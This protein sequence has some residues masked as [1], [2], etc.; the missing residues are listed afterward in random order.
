M[1]RLP[2][3]PQVPLLPGGPLA[4]VTKQV[5]RLLNTSQAI[6]IALIVIFMLPLLAHLVN[7]LNIRLMSDAYE[8]FPAQL[9]VG[10]QIALVSG[11]L[12]GG[13]LVLSWLCWQFATALGLKPVR[14]LAL[15]GAGLVSWALLGSLPN[16]YRV[17][18]Y[19]PQAL[20]DWVP[21]LLLALQISFLLMSRKASWGMIGVGVL[22]VLISAFGLPTSL[23]QIAL[24][25]I[26]LV[27]FRANPRLRLAGIVMLIAAPVAFIAAQ[28][29]WNGG[30]TRPFIDSTLWRLGNAFFGGA[31]T[32]IG[33]TLALNAA[34]PF[35]LSIVLS[36]TAIHLF[37]PARQ[38]PL[39]LKQVGLRVIPVVLV[40]YLLLHFCFLGAQPLE[41]HAQVILIALGLVIGYLIGL[42]IRK[43]STTIQLSGW[44]MAL[45]TLL[46]I[47]GPIVQA[48][49]TLV[50]SRQMAVYAGEWDARDQAIREAVASGQQTGRVR[51]LAVEM[52]TFAGLP[53][54]SDLIRQ[55]ELNPIARYYGLSA[56][57]LDE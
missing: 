51:A 46:L 32:W 8:G 36:A 7:M 34:V 14:V 17:L 39:P 19:I 2:P 57:V 56:L 6:Q 15:L 55:G 38:S 44:V 54:D 9:G 33:Q 4:P 28:L 35:I 3:Q 43:S 48:G 40:A 5:N 53:T 31:L 24:A 16:A 41:L 50:E 20:V 30:F 26:V 27:T 49:R 21:L 1:T 37:G 10:G 47:A 25:L 18:Y 22:A 42:S 52:A 13:Y 12:V 45:V 29:I 23:L 11:L